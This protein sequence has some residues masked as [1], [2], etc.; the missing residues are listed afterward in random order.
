MRNLR[1]NAA[2]VIL[3]AVVVLTVVVW[4][5]MI[6]QPREEVEATW[7]GV[8]EKVIEKYAAEAGREPVE[9]LINTDRGDLLLFVFALGGAIAGFAG[10]YFWRQL[11]HEKGK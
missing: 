5:S 11:I 3:T 7:S 2:I 4:I 6:T 1:R 10:G 8:D 9:P